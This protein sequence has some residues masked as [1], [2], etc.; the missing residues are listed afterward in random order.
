MEGALY[1]SHMTVHS[2]LIYQLTSN[3]FCC[4]CDEVYMIYLV[5]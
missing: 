1:L 4:F 5:F 2:K 3:Y